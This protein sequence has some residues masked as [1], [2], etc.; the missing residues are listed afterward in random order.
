ML[1]AAYTSGDAAPLSILVVDNFRDGA[2]SL[3]DLLRLCGYEVQTAYDAETALAAQCPD[4][5]ILELRLPGDDGWELVRRLRKRFAARQP[6][7]IAVTTCG[8][9]R[10]RRRSEA[11][12][13]HAH[14]L[15]P[16]E[17]GV[18]M[19]VLKRFTEVPVE[20]N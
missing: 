8:M 16:L 20:M 13:G 2:D 4:V 7:F 14:L 11:A 17:P 9:E 6:E 12:G 10:D 15:K 5:V 1:P 19:S 3:A 18:L